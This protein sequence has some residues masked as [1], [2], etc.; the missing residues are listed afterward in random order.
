MLKGMPEIFTLYIFRLILVLA[1]LLPG[2]KYCS[3]QSGI[4]GL[5][6]QAGVVR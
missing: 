6:W 4:F 1:G 3:Q 2:Y 5:S